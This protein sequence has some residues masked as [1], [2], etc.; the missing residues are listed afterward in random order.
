M[1][2]QNIIDCLANR[3]FKYNNHTDSFSYDIHHS[4]ERGRSSQRS[5]D[6]YHS[7]YAQSAPI[8]IPKP[9]QP[10]SYQ[11]PQ[12]MPVHSIRAS[13][14]TSDD[15]HPFAAL[16]ARTF[17]MLEEHHITPFYDPELRIQ[18]LPARSDF[19]NAEL[20]VPDRLPAPRSQ[21]LYQKVA[22]MLATAP[23]HPQ[24]K[25][26]SITLTATD[27]ASL[28]IEKASLDHWL[29]P[30][31]APTAPSTTSTT[32]SA[33]F[34]AYISLL[35]ESTEVF[36][37]LT[38]DLRALG[39]RRVTGVVSGIVAVLLEAKVGGRDK[40]LAFLSTAMAATVCVEESEFGEAVAAV[41][42]A[43]D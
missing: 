34:P 40:A 14:V 10:I 33:S 41:R 29:V 39:T 12:V 31:A 23:S 7:P 18:Q 6:Q 28:W 38:L 13:K 30:S 37:P 32:S 22:A 42:R 20:H 21:L 2:K 16:R 15:A 25:F 8:D 5:I 11:K 35:Q 26:F 19:S 24:P 36:I 1:H 43:M 27:P 3:G 9:G 17:R 4:P